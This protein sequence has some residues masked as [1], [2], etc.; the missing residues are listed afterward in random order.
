VG[1]FI[2]SFS[3][4]TPPNMPAAGRAGPM[5]LRAAGPPSHL[6]TLH[7]CTAELKAATMS[8]FASTRIDFLQN[9]AA[10]LTV[11]SPAASAHLRSFQ[12]QVADEQGVA[13]PE[14]GDKVCTACG[15][16]LIPGWSCKTIT[17][18][19]KRARRSTAKRKPGSRP[20]VKTLRLQCSSC[21]T[22]AT[23]QSAKPRRVPKKIPTRSVPTLEIAQE[24][25]LPISQSANLQSP[26]VA[27]TMAS[28]KTRGKKT[29]LQALLAANQQQQ[30]NSQPIAKRG[31]D[32]MDF[33]KA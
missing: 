4:E 5:S 22:I 27:N 6:P 29:S 13:I 16:L 32:L 15:S 25:N 30:R 9:A 2:E 28:R 11:S 14:A 26:K 1:I 8:I 31:L 19:E 3:L 7:T 10:L 33:M 20:D 17:H 12:H 21:N 24:P 23:L 18:D